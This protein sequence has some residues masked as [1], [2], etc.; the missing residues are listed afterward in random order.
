MFCPNCGREILHTADVCP[1]CGFVVYDNAPSTVYPSALPIKKKSIFKEIRTVLSILGT[2]VT[3]L[4]GLSLCTAGNY[5]KTDFL[6][7]ETI[8]NASPKGYSITYDEMFHRQLEDVQWEYDSS[9]D[10][11]RVTGY[12]EGLFCKFLFDIDNE[13]GGKN[14]YYTLKEASVGGIPFTDYMAVMIVS[15]MFDEVSP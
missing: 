12:S 10:T 3:I 2:I 11:V 4:F 1:Y 9:L 15:E 7:I 13:D 6:Y 5:L 8:K 14:F